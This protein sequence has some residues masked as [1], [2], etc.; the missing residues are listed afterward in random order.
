VSN[1][2]IFNRNYTSYQSDGTTVFLA[3]GRGV[4]TNPAPEITLVAGAA[5]VAGACVAASG[6]YVIPAT[7]LSGS[8]TYAFSPIG[9]AQSSATVGNP[10]VINLDGVVNLTGANITAESSLVPGQYYYLSKFNGQVVRY[11][12]ASG[13]ISGS[14]SN[15]Y[16]ASSPVGVALNGN[17][18]SIEIA[19]PV[20][21][22]T[23]A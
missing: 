6:N 17:Q 3:N 19:P 13:I 4:V 8:P 2:S 5:L 20:L 21:L 1:R 12:T 11:S 15:A 22:Y 9:F 7:A 23:G 18:L 14:G 10:V 16:A